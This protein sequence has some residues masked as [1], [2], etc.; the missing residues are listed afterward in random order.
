M[1][2]VFWQNCLSPHQLPYIVRLL[3]DKRVDVVVVAAGEDISDERRRMGWDVT[4]YPGLDRCEVYLNPMPQTV[5]HLLSV[6][7]EDSYH[8]FSGIRGFPFVFKV[9]LRSLRYKLRRGLITERP[10]TYAFNR[11]NGKPL[12]LH[13]IRFFF[14]DRKYASYIRYV[15]AMG[16]EA[17]DYFHSVWKKWKVFPFAYC[18]RGMSGSPVIPDIPIDTPP[19][20]LFIG[21][22]SNRKAPLDILRADVLLNNVNGGDDKLYRKRI[23][24]SNA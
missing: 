17:V 14:Q 5:E 9:F 6:R 11:A 22:L 2:I 8:L 24:I 3:E 4:S 10:N 12:W 13:R 19:R 7:P 21:G 23:G 18:T 1:R 15:F 20:F 16:D